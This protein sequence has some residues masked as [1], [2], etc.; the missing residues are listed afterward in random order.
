[1]VRKPFSIKRMVSVINPNNAEHLIETGL[2]VHSLT[3]L[4]PPLLMETIGEIPIQRNIFNISEN[5]VVLILNASRLGLIMLSIYFFKWPPFLCSKNKLSQLRELAYLFL[6]IPLIFPHQQ[7]YAFALII[8][9][10]FYLSHF[11]VV[12]SQ[13]RTTVT[14]KSNWYII[15]SLICCSFILMTLSTD[16]IIG[17][18][19]NTI[20][21]HFKS[22]TWGTMLLI[23]ALLLATPKIT[24]I[25]LKLQLEKRKRFDSKVP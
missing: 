8:P 13:H 22:I 2:G 4:I 10:I 19:L 3:A 23:I 7:K 12:N 24:E 18:E 1:M 5:I 15:I 11:L 6:I 14:N 21:Q 17:R 20:T 25:N 9:A 16:G